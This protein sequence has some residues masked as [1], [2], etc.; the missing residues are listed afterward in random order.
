MTILSRIRNRV[1][2]LV[3]VIFVAILAFVLTD[4]F[5][6]KFGLFS[7]TGPQDVGVINGHSVTYKDFQN[8]ISE[9]SGNRSLS[10]DEQK[11]LS[12]GVWAE[13][14]DKYIYEPEYEKLGLVVSDDELADQM[15]GDEPSEKMNQYFQDPQTGRIVEKFANPDGKLNGKAIRDLVKGFAPKDEAQWVQMETSMRKSLV[16]DKYNTLVRKG[17]YVTTA[18]AKR[19]YKDENTKYTFN[20]FVKRYSDVADSTIKCTDEELMTYYK[21]NPHKFKQKNE[22]RNIEFVAFEINP[23]ADDIANQRKELENLM[24]DFKKQAESV[25]SAFVASYASSGQY[26]VNYLQVGTFPPG[27]DSA[28]LNA[29]KSEVLG[30]FSQSEDLVIYKVLGQ[31]NASD[32][33]KVRHILFSFAG[34]PQAAPTITRTKEQAKTLAD[35]V[36]RIIKGGKKMEDLVETY[37]DDPGSKNG[38]K[39]DYGWFTQA[40][41]FVQPFKDAGFNYPKGTIQIVET[42]FGYHIIQTLDKTKESRKVKVVAIDRKREPSQNT[43]NAISAKAAEFAGRN[44]SIDLFNKAVAAEKLTKELGENITS[45][46]TNIANVDEP[47]PVI[48]WMFNEKTEVG[49]ISE[50]FVSNNKV[51][52]CILTKIIEKGTKPFDDKDVKV[53]CETEVRKKK[54]A[55]QFVKELNSKKATTLDAWSSNVKIPVMEGQVTNFANP[56]IPSMGSDGRI[57]GWMVANPALNKIS[58]PLVGD[59]GVYVVVITKVDQPQPQKP[60]DVKA[61]QQSLT[62]SLGGGAD[63]RVAEILNEEAD[64]ID[65]RAKY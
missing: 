50:P 15:M 59:L 54:K 29:P 30:P 37:T 4:I 47:Q 42:M 3:G 40:T 25:D 18:Q 6:G 36:L 57:V 35:S 17:F 23:T 31:I 46:S 7:N 45:N 9:Y 14:I 64:I 21:A 16:R 1:G 34:A 2:L 39:G 62:Q 33:A 55:E 61:K 48:R 58:V 13:F 63:S 53:I 12:E 52:V 20:Y 24:P 51:L 56:A 38:N 28:F 44:N 60:E 10:Q 11:Q 43:I 27:T 32:S 22:T 26:Q 5:S 41:G 19:E 49:T 8:K 65:D